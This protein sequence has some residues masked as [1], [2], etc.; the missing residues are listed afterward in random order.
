MTD[1]A[2]EVTGERAARRT[3]KNW[4]ARAQ[5][6]VPFGPGLGLEEAKDAVWEDVE[7]DAEVRLWGRRVALRL[8]RSRKGGNLDLADWDRVLGH[9]TGS[10]ARFAITDAQLR[11]CIRYGDE[12]KLVADQMLVESGRQYNRW[13]R[14]D[15]FALN[16]YVIHQVTLLR[17]GEAGILK[18]IDR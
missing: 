10:L 9:T 13:L 17:L 8:A 7:E 6:G 3:L 2:E 14:D 11:R 5:V 1:E 16:A 4:A 12:M 15:E 18:I